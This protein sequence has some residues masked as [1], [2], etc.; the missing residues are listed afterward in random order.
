MRK[1]YSLNLGELFS[2]RPPFFIKEGS[3]EPVFHGYHLAN[4]FEL[5]SSKK[6]KKIVKLINE[7]DYFS[8]NIQFKHCDYHEG[9]GATFIILPNE[10]RKRIHSNKY[11]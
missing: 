4:V 11:K 9:I 2:H 5:T 6:G 8:K 7:F 1:K 10:Y 3:A